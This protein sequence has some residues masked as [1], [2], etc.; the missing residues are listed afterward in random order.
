VSTRALHWSLY[1]AR[2]IQSIQH[3]PV[4]P[5]SILILTTL[6]CLGLPSGRFPSGKMGI[7][8]RKKARKKK[9]KGHLRKN[10]AKKCKEL[11]GTGL[12]I[13]AVE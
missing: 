11:L 9:E 4:T 12:L 6:L 2:S 5:T 13:T 1:E 10:K 8:S 3:H 7:R